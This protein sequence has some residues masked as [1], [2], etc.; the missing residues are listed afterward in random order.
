MSFVKARNFTVVSVVSMLTAVLAG[1][2]NA[3]DEETGSVDQW[4]GDTPH[5]AISGAFDGQDYNVR[6]EGDDAG[7]AHL[8]CNRIYAPL[9][10]ARPNADGTWD[11]SQLYFVTKEI[12]V[13]FDINGLPSEFSIGYWR[14]DVKAGTDLEI[15]QRVFGTSIPEG[16]TWADVQVEPY[17]GESASTPTKPVR[18]AEGGTI[19]VKLNSGSPDQGGVYIPSGG[20]LGIFA[21]LNWGPKESLKISATSDC[22]ESTVVLWARSLI[23][24]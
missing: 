4:L 17:T 12:A 11:T 19:S 6:L 3:P 24:P 1:C 9:P 18:A 21:S 7:A 23:S 10:G 16:K 13:V 22:V 8:T 5:Y 14:H 2:T 15:I 20:R